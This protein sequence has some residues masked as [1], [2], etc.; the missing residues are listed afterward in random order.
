MIVELKQIRINVTMRLVLAEDVEN[1]CHYE[2]LLINRKTMKM[3][4]DINNDS[5]KF[6]M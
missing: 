2:I 6:T 3:V 1:F 4:I 5:F